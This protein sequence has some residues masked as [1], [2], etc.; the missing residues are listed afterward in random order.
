MAPGLSADLPIHSHPA[1]S[2]D[3]P[4]DQP[5][6]PAPLKPSG[7]LDKFTFEETTPIIGREYPTVNIVDDLL[8]APNSD[9]LVRDLAITSTSPNLT[10]TVSTPSLTMADSLPT[11]RRLL[12]RSNQSH[13]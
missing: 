13:R 1:S 6:Y 3:G 7:A 10:P 5:R 9:E 8:N 11:R 12:P 2:G 4:T